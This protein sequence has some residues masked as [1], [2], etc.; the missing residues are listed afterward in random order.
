MLDVSG[1]SVSY[2]QHVALQD[3]D[4]RVGKGEIVVILGANG[5]GKTTLLKALSGVC[6]GSVTGTVALDGVDISGARPDR[7]VE[8]GLALVP[9]GRG[10]F[11]DLKVEENLLLGAYS[12][13]AR[14]E[15]AGN[16]D[17]VYRLFPKL[18]ERRRQVVRTMSGGEQQMVAIGRAMM[19]NPVVL[20][21]D[22]PSLGLSP[23]LCKELF[24]SLQAVRDT[25]LGILLVEQNAK[26][27]LAVA[28][29]GYLLETGRIVQEDSAEALRTDPA[30]Q[31]AYL[32]GAVAQ[33][34][35]AGRAPAPPAAPTRPRAEPAR[36]RG[37]PSPSE[38]AAAAMQGIGARQPARERPAA[39]PTPRA[40]TPTAP[41]PQVAPPPATDRPP[42]HAS[43]AA[44]IDT[45]ALVANA[46]ARADRRPGVA[47]GAAG[48][49]GRLP[50]RPAAPSAPERSSPRA[51]AGATAMPDLGASSADRLA[52]ILTEI[53]QA[54]RRAETRGAGSGR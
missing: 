54:A 9:E 43:T 23:L 7:I 11:G 15:E 13:R 39:A 6:E 26:Q 53:E 47:G 45:A 32:G 51:P 30:V 31:R 10:V 42:T 49:A 40:A 17:Q 37:G 46:T 28:D 27:S 3:A 14:D 41:R 22:E 44:G 21:L 35:P 4:L 25:G 8:E 29:R 34:P 12:Q 50:S 19:S 24:R 20:A 36:E 16:I 52:T 38:I 1:L 5:A 2:G 18:A 48:G 33:R